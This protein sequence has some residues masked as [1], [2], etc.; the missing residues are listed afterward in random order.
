MPFAADTTNARI[1]PPSLRVVLAAAGLALVGPI[2]ARAADVISNAPEAPLAPLMEKPLPPSTPDSVGDQPSPR[3]VYISGHWRWQDG[4]YVWEAGHWELPPSATAAWVAPR[5]EAKGNGYVLIQGAWHENADASAMPAEAVVVEPAP[6][7]PMH[8]VIVERPSP[9]HVWIAGYWGWQHNRYAWVPGRWEAPPRRNVVW[10]APRWEHREH[11][12]I[13]VE[14]GWRDSAGPTV[15]TEVAIS[16]P[17]HG[18]V[19]HEAPPPLRVERIV[20]HERPSSRHVWVPG[21]WAWRGGRYVWLA[22]HWELPPRGS[23]AWIEPRWELR[24][25]TY[26]LIEGRWH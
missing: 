20:E 10:V 1:F 7:P 4:A 25:G 19:I 18:V 8:E 17:V 3:H 24:H 5:W 15:R 22:G 26:V 16:G 13:F 21:Y 6:P 11:G 2:S 9:H 23:R 14:G 12:F